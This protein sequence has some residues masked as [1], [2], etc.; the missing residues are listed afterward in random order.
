MIPNFATQHA[1]TDPDE[2]EECDVVH[3]ESCQ[4][5]SDASWTSVD[6]VL[7][8]EVDVF[9]KTPGLPRF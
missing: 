2:A 3:H 4:F 7:T 1:L 8:R 5:Q 9:G 6:E